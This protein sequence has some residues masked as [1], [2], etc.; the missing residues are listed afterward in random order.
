MKEAVLTVSSDMKITLFN[1][2]AEKLFS[3]FA[4]DILH[5][6]INKT[7]IKSLDIIGENIKVNNTYRNL[8]L[9]FESGERTKFVSVN[10]IPNYDLDKNLDNYT[11]IIND[12]TELKN[13]EEQTKRNEKL[14]AMGELASGVAH[15][16]RNP[17]NSIGMIGQRLHREFTPSAD[18]N[19]YNNLTKLL[20]NEVS[21]VNK[22]ITQFLQYAKPLDLRIVKVEISKLMMD[23]YH[24]FIEQADQRNIEFKIK[25]D[26]NIYANIDP[27]LFKQAIINFIQNAFDAVENNGKVLVEYFAR[28][29]SLMVTI[30]DNGRGI[31]EKDQSKIFDLYYTTRKEGTG[32][33]LSIS[34]KIISQHNGIIDFTSSNKG[35]T[36]NIKIPYNEKL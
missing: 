20:T 33:G 3:V 23:F 25:G 2:S 34:Q 11:I 17:I 35:T 9:S 26:K 12:I 1:I 30:K 16:I 14:L 21:R 6:E 13:I 7:G 15:E 31:L 18:T 29:G 19:E 4:L 5:K 24:L 27:E 32:V 28:D 8:E 22:I 10:I 36:F